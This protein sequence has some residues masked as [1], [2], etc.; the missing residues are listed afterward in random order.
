MRLKLL[1][2]L[3]GSVFFLSQT[4]IAYGI[5]CKKSTTA[6][7]G[8][9]DNRNNIYKD[10]TTFVVTCLKSKLGLCST[11]KTREELLDTYCKN[12]SINVDGKTK[13]ANIIIYTDEI[14]PNEP[15]S[16]S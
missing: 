8:Y 3:L 7:C 1:Y 2:I 5:T 4:P 13:K 10:K 6:V 9:A 11:S 15:C 12:V 16:A 14:L